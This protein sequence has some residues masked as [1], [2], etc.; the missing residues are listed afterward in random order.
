[1]SLEI[2]EKLSWRKW[3]IK[4][5]NEIRCIVDWERLSSFETGI[6]AFSKF[7]KKE[8]FHCWYKNGSWMNGENKRVSISSNALIS[9]TVPAIKFGEKYIILD[10]NHRISIFKP[11]IIYLDYIDLD[12]ENSSCFGDLL[13]RKNYSY[14]MS[15]TKKNIRK[16][17]ND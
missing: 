1:M 7:Q 14:F 9:I 6:V 8:V 10:G 2:H 5:K 3:L 15:K 17:K 12:E 11:G 4:Y 16:C 13:N